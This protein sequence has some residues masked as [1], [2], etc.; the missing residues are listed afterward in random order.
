[1]NKEPK[2]VLQVVDEAARA[3]CARL[4]RQA[5][6]AALA[7]LEPETGF[8]QATRVV[9]SINPAGNAI[10]LLSQLSAHTQA[11]MRDSRCSVLCGEPG[12]GDPLTYPRVT[13]IGRAQALARGDDSSNSARTI[14]LAAHPQAALY[15]D[16]GDFAFWQIE[17]D[18]AN[19][20]AGFGRAY[21]FSRQD[22]NLSLRQPARPA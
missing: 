1:M 12:D 13:L 15:A 21:E 6:F 20:N 10:M 19:L 16:F 11:L 8:P 18:R 3:L 7:S 17:F 14:Y 22:L 4:V 5:R 2:S 9:L